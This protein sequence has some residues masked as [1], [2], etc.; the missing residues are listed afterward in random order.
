MQRL[1]RVLAKDG[2]VLKKSR[3]TKYSSRY[4]GLGDF[5]LIDLRAGG[6]TEKD[7]DI[8]ALARKKGVLAR[9]EATGQ[10]TRS[11]LDSNAGEHPSSLATPRRDIPA[12]IR[13][14]TAARSM[15]VDPEP[16]GRPQ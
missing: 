15:I 1:N 10:A 13:A 8:E 4:G 16:L 2:D 7:V 3:P 6:I 14:R 5:Y 9:W 11:R 12:P